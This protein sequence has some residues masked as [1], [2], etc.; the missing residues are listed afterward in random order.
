MDQSVLA[1]EKTLRYYE[2]NQLITVEGI[3]GTVIRL[4]FQQ[5]GKDH[6]QEI[7]LKNVALDH[8]EFV[9]KFTSSRMMI[10]TSGSKDLS[11]F[12]VVESHLN[13]DAT[14]GKIKFSLFERNQLLIRSVNSVL[15]Y[16]ITNVQSL[17][18]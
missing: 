17:L 14:T 13:P 6:Q 10:V 18:F 11:E 7:Q 4:Y 2:V 5:G 3:Q 1:H 15:N 16:E 9:N 12:I 8:C